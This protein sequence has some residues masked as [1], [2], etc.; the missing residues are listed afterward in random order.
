MV[1]LVE[2][3]FLTITSIL[4]MTNNNTE[5]KTIFIGGDVSKGY[6]DFVAL[7]QNHN[8]IED[9]FQLDDTSIGH[10]KLSKIL[11]SIS[12]KH[13][14]TKIVIGF[15]STG[16]YEN[17]WVEFVGENTGKLNLKVARLN[18]IVVHASD[19][20]TLQKNK[21]DKIS[22]ISIAK[23]LA[24]FEDAIDF[25]RKDEWYNI[26]QQWKYITILTKQKVQQ[27][28]YLEK[29]LYAYNPSLIQYC[30]GKMPAWLLSVLER[31]PTSTK[32]KNSRPSALCKIPYVTIEKA[33]KLK[34]GAKNNLG[35]PSE[36]IDRIIIE[37]IKQLKNFERA[38]KDQFC[39]L[40]NTIDENDLKILN[41]FKG[42][43]D[44][45]AVGLLV[46]IGDI[47]RFESSKKLVAFFGVHPVYRQ[48]GDGIYGMHMSRDGRI[49]P[50]KILYMVTLSAI[51]YNSD[52][53]LFYLKKQLQGKNKMVAIGACM[54]KIVRI[55]W[56]MLSNRVLFEPQSDESEIEKIEEKLKSLKQKTVD[57][58]NAERRKKRVHQEFDPSSPVSR[59]ENKKRIEYS[60]YIKEKAEN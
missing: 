5:E 38:R 44:N 51:Q 54:N 27:Q 35:L 49:Q 16:G 23:Y 3:T 47:S 32:L 26:R 36:N 2:K 45:S 42:I 8:I 25:S 18:P 53:K 43:N 12:K 60:A 22:A 4:K 13:E 41:S 7:D 58:F 39:I 55:I 30:N 19:K 21:T 40:R 33:K 14:K 57:Q 29:L 6:C 28:N 11:F 1:R 24:R 34:Q 59:R 20:T 46:E 15:E 9:I 10:K 37:I 48:S 56:T 52:I 17:K 50:K 31:D